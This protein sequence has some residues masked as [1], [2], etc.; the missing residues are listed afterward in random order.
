MPKFYFDVTWRMATTIEVEA[1]NF[2][3]AMYMAVNQTVV[4]QEGEYIDD[5]MIVTPAE[6][7][8]E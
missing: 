8:Y 4:P 2:L 7:S 3:K 6:E 1:P 5:S